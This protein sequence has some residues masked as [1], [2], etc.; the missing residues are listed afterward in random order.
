M[1]YLLRAAAGRRFGWLALSVLWLGVVLPAW[2]ADPAAPP[3]RAPKAPELAPTNPPAVTTTNG[4]GVL[5]YP[6]GETTEIVADTDLLATR[7]LA[8]NLTSS[9]A[10]TGYVWTA[11][12]AATNAARLLYVDCQGGDDA[13]ARAGNSLLAWK[14]FGR[15][16][17]NAHAGDTVVVRSGVCEEFGVVTVPAGVSVVG[18]PGN[19]LR[20]HYDCDGGSVEGALVIQSGT[21]FAQMNVELVAEYAWILLGGVE[22]TPTNILLEGCM[23]QGK[24]DVFML[25]LGFDEEKD[26]N[27]PVS[28]TVRNCQLQSGWDVFACLWWVSTNVNLRVEG[29]SVEFDTRRYRGSTYSGGL[30][31]FWRCYTAGGIITVSDVQLRWT[32]AQQG[33]FGMASLPVKG[34]RP[35]ITLSGIWCDYSGAQSVEGTPQTFAEIWNSVGGDAYGSS[36]AWVAGGASVTWS[37]GSLRA[38]NLWTAATV[39]TAPGQ[40]AAIHQQSGR[41]RLAAGSRVFTVANSLVTPASVVVATVNTRGAGVASVIAEPGAGVIRLETDAVALV[42]CDLSWTVLAP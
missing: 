21:R 8:T 36:A 1:L 16:I 34:D 22:A 19:H 10:S 14:T 38:S 12:T 37:S 3:G 31:A 39:N 15:A 2:S 24:S 6:S 35:R 27:V 28:I 13:T 42:P 23:I 30:G 25:L 11:M 7:A 20:L 17:S 4:S 40:V 9:L 26:H 29:C 32:Y 33:L 18:E 5:L 41:V